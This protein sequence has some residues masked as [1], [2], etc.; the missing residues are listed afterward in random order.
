MLQ[1]GV[2]LLL[3]GLLGVRTMA[4]RS[5]SLRALRAIRASRDPRP[6][7]EVQI[8]QRLDELER[9]GLVAPREGGL[10]ATPR[11]HATL[12]IVRRLRW[13]AGVRR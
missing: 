13:V 9:L 8:A 11:G 1:A 4:Q 3:F 10:V 5:V 6:G 7:F 12:R 2:L